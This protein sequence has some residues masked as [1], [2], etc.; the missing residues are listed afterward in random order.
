MPFVDALRLLFEFGEDEREL[1]FNLHG[2]LEACTV[3]VR[4]SVDCRPNRPRIGPM[5]NADQHQSVDSQRLPMGITVAD[6]GALNSGE[7]V[8]N[9]RG[10]MWSGSKRIQYQLLR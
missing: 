7:R 2:D 9:G 8:M 5:A 4:Q 10:I 3:G 1:V 6:Q